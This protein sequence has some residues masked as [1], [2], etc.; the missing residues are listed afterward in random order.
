MIYTS[1]FVA[2]LIA[3]YQ[4]VSGQIPIESAVMV[5]MLAFSF[6]TSIRRLMTTTHDALAGIAASSRVAEILDQ[7]TSR[8]YTKKS[9]D[10]EDYKG[11]R[12]KN[13]HFGYGKREVLNGVDIDIPK[14][15]SVAI[16]G[17]SGCGKS[18]TAGLLER[19]SDPDS[20]VI[21]L[22]GQDIR[23]YDIQD[24]RKMII[25]VPQTV[26]IFSGTIAENLRVADPDA[27]DD[28]LLEA[29]DEVRLKD[30]VLTFPGGLDADVGDAG[31]RLSGGER[32]KIG[33]A[34]ALLSKAPYIIFDEATSSVDIDSENEIWACLGGLAGKKTLII[35]SHRLSTIQNAD[36]IYVLSS[37][38]VAEKGCHTELMEK[39]GIYA[40]LVNSQRELELMGERRVGD[41]K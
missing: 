16:V 13:V 28:M 20:G 5:L 11:I 2:T 29:L 36:M 38:K 17:P 10:P 1:V 24:I 6:F 33:I 40:G 4:L 27:T 26:N 34:R 37:G 18:T 23:S 30:R 22:D 31:A 7:D 19:F 12:V 39:G 15:S 3:C 8:K 41:G 9:D 25:T 21:E 35:I 14:D 32:Q